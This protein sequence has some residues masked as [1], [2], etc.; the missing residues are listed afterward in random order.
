MVLFFSSL[1]SDD[2]HLNASLSVQ[3]Q[4]QQQHQQL[5]QFNSGQQQSITNQ[6]HSATM[7]D[8]VSLFPFHAVIVM[9][10][11]LIALLMSI[12]TLDIFFLRLLLLNLKKETKIKVW[13]VIKGWSGCNYGYLIV[14]INCVIVRCTEHLELKMFLINYL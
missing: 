13:L 7:S 6:Y 8:H 14:I 9:L 2:Q 10:T 11:R 3:G 4:Q 12:I 1:Q 5:Q